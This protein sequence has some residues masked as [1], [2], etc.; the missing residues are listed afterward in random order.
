MSKINIILVSF[1][2]GS[3]SLTHS[4][5]AANF[6]YSLSC[7]SYL[8]LCFFYFRQHFFCWPFALSKFVDTGVVN[9]I[10]IP[11]VQKD[12]EYYI[13]T[14]AS[15]PVH[16]GHSNYESKQVINE[17]IDGLSFHKRNDMA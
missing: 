13:I 16:D 1:L 6:C 14:K 4:I 8:S 15:Q 2:P 11:L 3:S 12:E 5:A 10:L 9:L 7:F 17:C